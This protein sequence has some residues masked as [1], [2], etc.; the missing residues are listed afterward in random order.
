MTLLL[1]LLAATLP[2]QPVNAYEPIAAEPLSLLGAFVEPAPLASY[3]PLDGPDEFP[4]LEY[5]YIEANYLTTDSE[6]ADDTLDGWE[7]TGSLE[8][9]LNFFL[10]GTAQEQSGDADI[11]KYRIGA[12]WHFGFLKRFD[13]YG[14]ISYESFEI[15]DSGDDFDDDSA[16]GELGLRVLIT[17]RIEVNGRGLWSDNGEGDPFFGLG[18]RFYFLESLSAGARFDTDGNDD[19]ISLGLRFEI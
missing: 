5:T 17:K 12:G 11:T 13:A 14:I 6:L 10:Q 15:E 2:S 16:A 19:L 4:E 1:S 8:L 3:A 7:I 9:P 18:A